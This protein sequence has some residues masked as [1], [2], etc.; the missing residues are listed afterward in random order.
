MRLWSFYGV[1]KG[2]RN[3]GIV[4]LRTVIIYIA[5]LTAMR[6]MGKRQIGELELSELVI[7]VLISDIA[8]HP[9]QDI[10]IPLMN[11]LLPVITLFCFE[12]IMAGVIVKSP[13]AKL[14]LCGRP[15]FLIVK[16]V[17][18]QEEMERNRFSIDEL[19]E[20]LR[21]QSVTDISKVEYAVLE[22]DGKVSIILFPAERPA[23]AGQLQVAVKDTGY[24]IILIS[25]GRLRSENLKVA[26]RD[27]RWLQNQLEAHHVKSPREVY[28]MSVNN[29]GQVYFAKTEA[30]K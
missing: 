23:T 16:G 6:L 15:S 9:L 29:A 7:A 22:T 21:A 8:A 10:G 26:G 25:N 14:F 13:R 24:P 2:G 19:A 27:E 20:E 1:V 30:G 3:V 28:F 12:L 11:G 17:I 4:F 18:C 5:L